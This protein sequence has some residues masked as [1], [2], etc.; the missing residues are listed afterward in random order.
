MSD[1]CVV[2][3]EFDISTMRTIERVARKR[4]IT[5]SEVVEQ[6]V[7]DFLAWPEKKRQ[8]F[9]KRLQNQENRI[10]KLEGAAK[11]RGMV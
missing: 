10:A 3:M 5:P 11:R 7:R 2:P 6:A 4:G 8:A 1:K 9:I